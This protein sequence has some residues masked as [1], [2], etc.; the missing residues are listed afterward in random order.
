MSSAKLGETHCK[1]AIYCGKDNK[2]RGESGL[3][4]E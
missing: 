3:R 2:F 1:H 4:V